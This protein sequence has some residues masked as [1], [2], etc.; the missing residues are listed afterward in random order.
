MT[1]AVLDPAK[2][3]EYQMMVAGTAHQGMHCALSFVGDQ[4][5]LYRA[6][7]EI[8]PATSPELAEIDRRLRRL[9]A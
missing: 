6:L 9:L 3:E 2:I 7:R 5:G 4:L 1:T 8:S